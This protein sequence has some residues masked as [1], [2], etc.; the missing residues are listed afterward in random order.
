MI[1]L[2]ILLVLKVLVQLFYTSTG[3]GHSKLSHLLSDNIC[4]YNR[5]GQQPGML[6]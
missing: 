2:Q 3:M 6:A 5:Y 4:N 1:F